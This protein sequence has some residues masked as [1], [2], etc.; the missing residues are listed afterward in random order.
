[1]VSRVESVEDPR[2]DE[3]GDTVLRNRREESVN[4]LERALLSSRGQVHPC[5]TQIHFR[6]IGLQLRRA[7]E[8]RQRQ[9]RVPA[10][11]VVVSPLQIEPSGVGG[12][13]DLGLLYIGA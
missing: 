1:M 3:R 9:G 6:K 4:L 12:R 2:P 13:G 11:A 7:V 5:S 10:L 8:V